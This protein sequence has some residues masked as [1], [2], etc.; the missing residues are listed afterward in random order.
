MGDV[1]IEV[2]PA[3]AQGIYPEE[4]KPARPTLESFRDRAA[5]I[6]STVADVA[7]E[8][9]KQFDAALGKGIGLAPDR[10]EIEFGLELQAETGVVIAKAS[11]G[12]TLTVKLTW[13]RL[14]DDE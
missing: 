6:A 2:R 11:A 9:K 4:L 7:Q 3:A 10:V 14:P 8:L 5:D 1:L 13:T 12:C